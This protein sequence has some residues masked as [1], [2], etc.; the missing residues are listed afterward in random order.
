MKAE[1]LIWTEW[2]PGTQEGVNPANLKTLS[3]PQKGK[4]PSVLCSELL[5]QLLSGAAGELRMNFQL[6]F[7][8]SQFHAEGQ[9]R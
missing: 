7:R 3:V 8:S 2:G 4:A 1:R 6:H 9:R 5:L